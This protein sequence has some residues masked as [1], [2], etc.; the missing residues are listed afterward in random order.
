MLHTAK[1]K[2]S[3]A[4]KKNASVTETE[5]GRQGSRF[6]SLVLV[7]KHVE[8]DPGKGKDCC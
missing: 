8:R 4:A 7:L 1:Q 6:S 5:A 2:V 3:F